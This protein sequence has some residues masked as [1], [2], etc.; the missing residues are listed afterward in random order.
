MTKLMRPNAN[1][2][3]DYFGDRQICDR[4]DA[5]VSSYGDKCSAPLDERCQGFETYDYMLATV[6]DH[7]IKRRAQ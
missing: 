1:D 2:V 4:C 3:I 7:M 6:T 5:T